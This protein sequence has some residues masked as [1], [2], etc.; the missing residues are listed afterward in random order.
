MSPLAFVLGIIAI[1]AGL[2]ALYRGRAFACLILGFGG[3]MAIWWGFQPQP[4]PLLITVLS[5]G[6]LVLAV[7]GIPPLRRTLL[8]RF[9]F[10]VMGRILPRISET[11]R[12][13]L[14]AGTVWWDGELFSGRPNWKR[15]AD[16]QV[17]PLSTEERAFLDG[18]V[19]ELC[20]IVDDHRITRE[21]D[22]PPEIWDFLRRNRFFGMIIPVEHGGLGFSAQAHSAVVTKV[23]G[24]SSATAVSV[25][26]PNSLGPAE[27]ILHYG[28]DEQKRRYLPRLA[29]GEEIPCFALTEPEAGSD[30]ASGQS[31]GIV[32]RGTFDGKEV[33]GMR[34]NWDKR[35]ATLA[36]VATVIGLAFKL[37]DPDHLLGQNEDLGIT[38]ALVPSK[39]PGVDIG[40]R[41][42][43]LGVAFLNGPT[44]GHDVFLPLDY[45]IGGK[46]MAGQG[47]RMLMESLAAG[48]SISLPALS[49]G[50]AEMSTRVAGAY[51]TVREQFGLPIGKFEGI[52]ERLGRIAGMTYMMNATRR[53]TAGAVDAGE[54][55]SVISAMI[56]YSLT[57]LMRTVVND[58][59]DITAGA[60]ISRGPRNVMAMPYASLPIGIT[61][62][63]ANILTRCLIVFG[64]GAIR[65][66]PCVLDEI[67]S[68]AGNDLTRFDRAFF[69]HLGFAATN[70]WR[71]FVLGSTGGW[72]ARPRLAGPLD[73]Y[74]GE[75]S[76]L[77][78]SF[79]FLSELAMGTLGADLKRRE[80]ISGR[81]ADTLSWM[82]MGS[83]TLKRFID[84]GSPRE[85]VIYAEWALRTAIYKA[86]IAMDETLENFPVSWV[87][88]MR[89]VIFPPGSERRPPK[90]RLTSRVARSILEGGKGRE[91]LTQEI[92]VPAT[93]TPGLGLLED[94][95]AKTVEARPVEEKLRQAIRQRRLPRAPLR[96]L[97]EPA[98]EAN[99]ISELEA[100]L[101]ETAQIARTEA[102]QVDA[103]PPGYLTF[104]RERSPFP[105]E[106]VSQ[107]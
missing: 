38:C 93:S 40:R 29:R 74:A 84:D 22:L 106:P 9:I 60:G 42:D 69:R 54:K 16:F 5:A 56:K 12:Q 4:S 24:R 37:R 61:V 36:P 66:H 100:R 51:A 59:M 107:K 94:A 89:P 88:W 52:E 53:L 11:E 78:A 10:A 48:R 8:T 91:R 25:M 43:P 26:V 19:E 80:M 99:V 64:Q 6:A 21:G 34:L 68:V 1:T 98:M 3:L 96:D 82:Y 55:P 20:N 30:A 105:G 92:F 15:L 62:E 65:C 57:E 23:A 31:E 86:S 39:L 85:D 90:D 41:H 46:A 102:V 79:A 95:L 67:Q 104:R 70:A 14:E 103:F 32:C 35:Y 75:L 27:L 47:W 44:T 81:M 17:Q 73:V 77:S 18:P 28:T 101:L 33:L 2:I 97:L 50:G 45:I 49:V 87:R 7:L 72:F 13:A 76:R 58:A 71:S 83:A 63:G